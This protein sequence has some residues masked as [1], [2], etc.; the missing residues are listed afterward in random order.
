MCVFVCVC[1]HTCSVVSN[2][3]TSPWTIAREPPLSMEFSRQEHWNG[4]LF[5][6]LDYL[7]N[8]GIRTS[9]PALWGDSLQLGQLQNPK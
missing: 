6:P 2:S 8:Q 7:P 4:L 3:F 1:V 9:S 5:P